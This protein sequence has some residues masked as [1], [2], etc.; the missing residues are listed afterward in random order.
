MWQYHS[1]FRNPD[2]IILLA[3]P[4]ALC[5]FCLLH[6][7]FNLCLAFKFYNPLKVCHPVSTPTHVGAS[8]CRETCFQWWQASLKT[9]PWFLYC[10]RIQLLQPGHPVFSAVMK[11]VAIGRYYEFLSAFC[12]L[13][14]VPPAASA[15]SGTAWVAAQAVWQ[16]KR[17]TTRYKSKRETITAV[18]HGLVWFSLMPKEPR[19][20]LCWWFSGLFCQR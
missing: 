16:E 14:R 5:H 7:F 9:P 17:R 11:A 19:L 3:I 6:R 4:A 20:P 13:W 10:R 8:C 15:G 12:Q 2:G 18:G 1:C